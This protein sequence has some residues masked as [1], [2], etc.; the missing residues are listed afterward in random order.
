MEELNSKEQISEKG[1][2]LKLIINGT[3]FNWSEQYITGSKVRELGEISATEEIY[4]T[5]K[6]PGEDELIKD[7]TVV[8]LARPGIE[9]FYSTGKKV[10]IHIDNKPYKITK[11]EHS[12]SEIK[13]LG[14]I[15]EAYELEQVIDGQL[16]PLK[17]D[18]YVCIEGNEKFFGH[19]RDGSSS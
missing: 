11:G 7:D 2:T 18:A 19:P 6:K 15:P 12:V 17:D 1:H 14:K 16:T 8:D 10:T 13:V 5:I 9:K 4:L 3:H